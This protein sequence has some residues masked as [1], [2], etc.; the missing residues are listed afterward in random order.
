MYFLCIY[1]N[2]VLK[3]NIQVNMDDCYNFIDF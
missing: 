1:L 3:N 2:Y